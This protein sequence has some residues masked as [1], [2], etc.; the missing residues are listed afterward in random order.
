MTVDGLK[1]AKK[2]MFFSSR[3]AEHEL[4][5][6]AGPALYAL[7]D[8][9][10]GFGVPLAKEWIEPRSRPHESLAGRLAGMAQ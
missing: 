6:R 4:G 7:C 3:K 10:E 1:L 8:A 5:Y 2:K 9:I